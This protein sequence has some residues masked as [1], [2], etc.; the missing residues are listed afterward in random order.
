MKKRLFAA[1]GFLS[2]SLA[3]IL[4]GYVSS[5][6]ASGFQL[7]EENGVGVGDYDA[8][9]AAIAE[10]A[11]TA[12]YNPA[13]LTRLDH[14][15]FVASADG[16]MFNSKFTG[17]SQWGTNIGNPL[18]GAP[19]LPPTGESGTA[20][21]GK[22]GVI[23]SFYYSVPINPAMVFAAGLTVPFGLQTMWGD[24]SIVRY[25]ATESSLTVVDFTPAIGV[26]LTDQWSVG[27]GADIERLNATLSSMAGLPSFAL[28]TGLPTTAFDTESENTANDWGYGYHVGVLYQLTPDTRFG[29]AYHSQVS[30]EPT[31]NSEFEGPMAATPAP[32]PFLNT[33]ISNNGANTSIS[34]PAFTMLSGYTNITPI[35]AVMGSVTYTQWE[36]F[37]HLQLNNVEAVVPDLV[38]GG[39]DPTQI[40]VFIPENFRNTWRGSLG[41][42]VQLTDQWLLRG[43][44]GYDEN[45]TNAVDRNL[46]LPDGNRFA[47]AIGA[48]YQASRC[49]GLDVGYTH[50]FIDN[51]GINNTVIFGPQTDTT[52]GTTSNYANVVGAQITWDIA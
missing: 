49:I 10:D 35:W 39:F 6:M 52:I 1:K 9:G 4:T 8:G 30:F 37:N 44:V 41:T 7:F 18:T 20:Q 22:D 50:L 38:T 25:T 48:H 29:L 36:I 34:M 46:R 31:G 21:G 23:P 11:S 2:I 17:T 40:S 15:Q 51:G 33:Q 47:L 14:Q 43:G 45:P 16:I 3:G 26:K 42:S 28:A 24:D 19:L 32:T 13:G 27:A 5:A 12:F